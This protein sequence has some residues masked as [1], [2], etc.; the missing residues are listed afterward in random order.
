MIDDLTGEQQGVDDMVD[1]PSKESKP[2]AKY[3]LGFGFLSITT[4]GLYV[5]FIRTILFYFFGLFSLFTTAFMLPVMIK[6][7][8]K[9][10]DFIRTFFSLIWI[11]VSLVAILNSNLEITCTYI[12]IGLQIFGL[13]ELTYQLYFKKEKKSPS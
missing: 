4:V 3:L 12:I 11:V 8:P 7:G 1:E 5:P 6:E 13:F 10:N 9:G 2:W